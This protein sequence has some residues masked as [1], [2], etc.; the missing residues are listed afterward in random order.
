MNHTRIRTFVA[1]VC[2][3]VAAASPLSAQQ[4][5]I[6]D[7]GTLGG[8][9]SHANGI[10]ENGIVA[11][12]A[13]LPPGGKHAVIWDGNGIVD[14][15]APAGFIVSEAAAVNDSNQVAGFGEGSPQS[16]QGYLWESGSWTPIGVLPGHFES[17]ALDIDSG[18]RIVGRSFILGGEQRAVMWGAGVLTDLG[19]LG[20]SS[21]AH[22]INDVGQV[23]GHSLADLPGG[24]Q[25]F[26]GFLWENGQMTALDPLGS[27]WY[28]TVPYSFSVKHGTLWR[29]HGG[30]VA[31]G[32][33]PP[34]P[35]TCGSAPLTRSIA[36]A[37]NSSGQVVGEAMCSSTGGPDAA[38]LWQDGVMHNLNDLIPSGTGWELVS[39]LDINDAGQIVGWGL[40]S[41]NDQYLR[42]YL[43]E[44]PVACTGDL[45]CDDG[46]FCNGAETCV[47]SSCQ[48]GS[49]PC[50]GQGCDEG[51]GTCGPLTCNNDDTCD[52]FED[53]DSC[54][55]D[56]ISG[57]GSPACGDGI[58]QPS[59]GED[60]LSCASDCRGRQK[61]NPNRQYCCG[62][63]VGCADARCNADP[64]VCDDTPPVPYCCGDGSCGGAEDSTNCA[65]DCQG[66]FCG[67]G[68]CDAGEDQCSCADDCGTPP[69]TESVC[70]DGIDNDCDQNTD[71]DD[72]DCTAGPDPAC[73]C[74]QRG[75]S[76]SGGSDCCSGTCKRNG[77]C[78]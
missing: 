61:G 37:I 24:E 17:M 63:D 16:Y 70:V 40:L 21:S 3:L 23:V 2:F 4:Y 26:R 6:V 5:E 20:D 18:G 49:D 27:S 39:A 31:L 13:Q 52:P 71:C 45:D 7:L 30:V 46:V 47:G 14:L 78:R 54:P 72:P 57:G 69:A 33:V 64:W 28:Y 25:E 56:C 22:G 35:G 12:W 73:L 50:P 53:C 36:R 48:A 60:C 62:T 66:S 74:G 10:S 43:L 77:T 58:C 9:R 65:I 19:T 68:N 29:N 55:D 15:G 44:P 67:D 1:T 41:P 38:F 34:T 75:D 59:N 32:D 76:C 8:L 42:A 51:A 11:G